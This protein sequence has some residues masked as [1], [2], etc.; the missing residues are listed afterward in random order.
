[1]LH[2]M[3]KRTEQNVKKELDCV[4]RG[5]GDNDSHNMCPRVLFV[6]KV[7]LHLIFGHILGDH[8][9]CQEI[10]SVSYSDFFILIKN[11]PVLNI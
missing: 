4:I 3:K 8:L 11:R 6:Q 10:D 1:M 5:P 7:P 9:Q 2:L